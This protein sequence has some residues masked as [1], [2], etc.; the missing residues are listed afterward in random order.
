MFTRGYHLNFSGIIPSPCLAFDCL[1]LRW[2]IA[3][4]VIRTNHTVCFNTEAAGLCQNM[5]GIDTFPRNCRQSLA[6]HVPAAG[7]TGPSSQK[8]RSHWVSNPQH[9]VNDDSILVHTFSLPWNKMNK[10]IQQLQHAAVLTMIVWTSN[11]DAS[12]PQ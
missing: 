12:K 5:A 11:Y 9:V 4:G 10:D 8:K 3:E 2:F 7:Q 6:S 1:L